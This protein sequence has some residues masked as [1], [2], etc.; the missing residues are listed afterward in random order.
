MSDLFLM[1]LSTTQAVWCVSSKTVERVPS[2]VTISKRV[3]LLRDPVC[4]LASI[5]QLSEQIHRASPSPGSQ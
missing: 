4:S 2:G 5:R 3:A 1:S